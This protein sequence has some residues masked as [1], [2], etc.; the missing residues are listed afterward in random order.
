MAKVT[1]FKTVEE[2]KF[3][4]HIYDRA[5]WH[6]FRPMAKT[7]F[8]GLAAKNDATS[9]SFCTTQH[10][11]VVEVRKVLRL[12][13]AFQKPQGY[14]RDCYTNATLSGYKYRPYGMYR[15]YSIQ[16]LYH[17]NPTTYGRDIVVDS[18]FPKTQVTTFLT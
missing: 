6:N 10:D 5:H 1:I 11:I 9:F 18:I 14:Y 7:Q 8:K 4:Q 15:L 17:V 2:E 12:A 3:W 13:N 16:I